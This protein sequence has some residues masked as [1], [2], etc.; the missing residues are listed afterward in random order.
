MYSIN[1][2]VVATDFSAAAERAVRRA[3]LMAKQLG[4]EL[5]LLHV[6]HP[7]DLYPG[8]QRARQLRYFGQ[9]LQE[10]SN[11]RLATLA[12]AL[13]QDFAI[14]VMAATRIGRVHT[15][16]ADYAKANAVGL[17]VAGA[18]GE[19]TLLNLLLGSTVSR[20]LRVADCPVLIARNDEVDNY[21]Q[22]IAAVDFSGGSAKVPA[23]A[24]TAAPGARIEV[25]HIFN[26]VQEARMY[27]GLD[28]TRLDQYC[29]QALAEAG[30]Q[31][32]K[33]LAEQGDDRMVGQV[34]TG[35]PPAEICTRAAALSADL[36]VLGRFGASGLE[37]WLLGGVS[38][39]VAHVADCDV[40][41]CC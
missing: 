3:A 30:A 31:L 10:A 19:N 33:I 5:H 11:N 25:L 7:L 39:D 37:E 17:V 9:I 38:K 4:A 41:L 36:I 18:R 35:Y 26:Q 14:P 20:L 12:S 22:V 24:R 27:E 1:R 29:E 13:N 40:L 28:D 16:I 8:A 32:D 6:V 21:R 2:I 23:L 15:Q 34:L